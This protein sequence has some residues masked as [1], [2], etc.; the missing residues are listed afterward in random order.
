[1]LNGV[2]SIAK[3]LVRDKRLQQT[4][5]LATTQRKEKFKSGEEEIREFYQK[6]SARFDMVIIDGPA[7]VNME[8]KLAATGVDIAVILTTPEYVS[9][10]DA[11]MMDQTLRARGVG[12]RVFIVNKINRDHMGLGIL[13]NVE[14]INSVMKIPLLGVIQYD[15]AIHFAANRGQPIVLQ[16]GNYIERNF[17]KIADRLLQ[18]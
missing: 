17:N 12:K 10:R 2:V 6:L 4:W 7:G 13:P 9:L 18:Y 8:L 11:D 16:K 1:V 3:A 14:T 15:D 5:L